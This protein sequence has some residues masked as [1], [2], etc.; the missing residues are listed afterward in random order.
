MLLVHFQIVF[1]W[2]LLLT[3]FVVVVQSLHF[4]LLLLSIFDFWFIEAKLWLID[5]LLKLTDWF[6]LFVIDDV[7][8]TVTYDCLKLEF[9]YVF[10]SLSRVIHNVFCEQLICYFDQQRLNCLNCSFFPVHFCVEMNV[11]CCC[12]C[13][14]NSWYV[15]LSDR[16]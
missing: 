2:F 15:I 11:C 14:W 12:C 6:V 5:W 1:N 7:I 9:A 10:L 3:A 4:K 16:V 13:C 8:F